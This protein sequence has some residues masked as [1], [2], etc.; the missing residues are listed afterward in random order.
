MTRDEPMIRRVANID[1]EPRLAQRTQRMQSSIIREL[2]KLTVQPDICFAGGLPA[3]EFFPVREFEEACRHVLST[4]GAA[5]LQYSTTEGD[6]GLREWLA[7]SMAKYGI[8]IEPDNIMMTNGS[9][10]ALDLI[11]KLF[12][13]PGAPVMTSAPT[14]LGALQAWNGYQATY[15]T[16][17]QDDDGVLVEQRTPTC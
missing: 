12:I 2:L 7:A 9:Q 4:N 8:W 5:A 15:V 3:P 10:Q 17:P 16:V 14:Y 6:R 13:D 1:W 11:G